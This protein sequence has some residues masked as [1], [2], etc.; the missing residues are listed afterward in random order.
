MNG[1]IRVARASDAE[2]V[3]AIYR[4]A[5][6]EAVTSFELEPPAAGEMAA[7]MAAV[8][9]RTPWIVCDGGSGVLGYAYASRHRDRAAYQWSVEVSAY[10][11][12]DAQGRG[13]G[14]A[15]YTSLFEILALQG[16]RNAYA[17]ITLPNPASSG[18]HRALGFTPVGIYRGV[19]YKNGAW[20]DV[21]W[22]ER[23]IAPQMVDPPSPVPF[24]ELAGTDALQRALDAGAPLLKIPLT[25]TAHIPL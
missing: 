8:L 24:P 19:G 15:L 25:A 14:R 6:T 17:G 1:A 3:A 16:F 11:R 10:V 20:H 9:E 12:S 21:E 2:A 22:L 7:R 4:P 18:M 23:S 13:V 5:V